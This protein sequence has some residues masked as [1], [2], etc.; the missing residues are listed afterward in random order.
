M[1]FC[2]P[3]PHFKVKNF[4]RRII[5][6]VRRRARCPCL[7]PTPPR[8]HARPALLDEYAFV[9]RPGGRLYTITD[10]EQLHAWMRDHCAAHPL[11][12]RVPEEDLVRARAVCGEWR[13]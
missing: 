1:F 6:C 4:R 3:D 7:S 2:F 5:T 10:V 8:T 9:L 11:F 12:R 13:V